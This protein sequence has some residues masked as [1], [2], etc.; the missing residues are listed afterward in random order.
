MYSTDITFSGTTADVIEDNGLEDL[1]NV[2]KT[3]FEISFRYLWMVPVV[4]GIPGNVLTIFVANR[5]HNKSL[6]P[7]IYMTAL[8]VSDTI[9]LIGLVL[10]LPV[11]HSSRLG[12]GVPHFREYL[13][14][15]H[16][17]ICYVGA[18]L[19]CL[20]LAEMSIDRVLAIRFPMVAMRLCSANRTRKV[21]AVTAVVFSLLNLNTFF[22]HQYVRDQEKG[23]ENIYIIFEDNPIVEVLTSGF[24]LI[25][26][27]FLPFVI[28]LCCNVIIIITV[29][30]ASKKRLKM[31]SVQGQGVDQR[32][33]KQTEH[34]TRIGV[35]VSAAYVLTTMPFRLYNVI[36][37]IPAVG[38][39]LSDDYWFF[40]FGA[41]NE[42][43]FVIYSCNHACNFYLYCVAGGRR[44]RTDTVKILTTFLHYSWRK[45]DVLRE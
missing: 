12:D 7:C 2:L 20:Y 30:L 14:K 29:K 27:A 25:F 32:N 31:D 38:Y 39:D 37:T 44:Y 28:I 13:F 24:Q 8:A 41:E 3:L 17:F 5:K 45:N 34:L 23:Y 18:M 22:T 33:R 42:F 15:F 43:L 10:F 9:Y 21:V 16:W 26:G 11:M 40:R 19:S 6:S 35:F 1:F 36:V 4:C